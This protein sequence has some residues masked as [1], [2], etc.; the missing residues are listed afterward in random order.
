ME[1]LQKPIS[2]NHKS[3]MFFD[4]VIATRHGLELRT[5]QTGE[6]QF[7]GNIFTGTTIIEMGKANLID[8]EVLEEPFVDILVDKFIAIYEEDRENPMDEDYIFDNFDDAVEVLK[9]L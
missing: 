4:G 9:Q 5:F 2:D 6:I 8:D 1:T 3:A 7:M